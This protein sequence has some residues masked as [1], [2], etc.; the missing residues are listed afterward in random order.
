[1]TRS[2]DLL[3]IPYTAYRQVRW[4]FGDRSP[5]GATLKLT[6]RCTLHCR[7]CPWLDRPEPDLP[8][9]RWRELI[10]EVHRRGARHLVLEGGEPTLREDLP[11]LIQLGQSL[12]M[13]VTLATNASRPLEAY[14][15]DRFLV[16]VDGLPPTHDRLRGQ[17][18]AERLLQNLPGARP[19]RVA[20]VSLS[21]ENAGEIEE[22][23]AFYA[24]RVEGFWFSFVYDYRPEDRLALSAEE[25]RRA[26]ERILRLRGRY[27]IVNLP[28]YLRSAGVPRPCR[29][30]LLL[31]V[32][33][34]GVIQPGC[35][36]AVS[37]PCRCDE[38]ELAC[39]REFSDFV[40]PRLYLYHL[41]DYLRR[42]P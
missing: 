2:G 12:G 13:K 17:G 6:T 20:L 5:F 24:G 18:A 37:G 3:Y 27:P 28:S 7:H 22:L 42:R 21:R 10:V 26:A 33:A 14:T 1:M 4:L 40:E 9:A 23:L 11:E 35:M 39:H 32:T 36:A 41:R 38:C 34:D 19:P 8:F 15:P 29:D 25:K 31:T 30:W 16:S